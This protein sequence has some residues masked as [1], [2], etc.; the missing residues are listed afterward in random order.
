MQT[1]ELIKL[2]QETDPTG[3]KEVFVYEEEEDK[4]FAILD[5]GQSQLDPN[6]VALHINA[7]C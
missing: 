7:D 1:R 4:C 5:G 3:E 2:L 6:G